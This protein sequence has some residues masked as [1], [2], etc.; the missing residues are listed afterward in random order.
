MESSLQEK[1]GLK[2]EYHAHIR[3]KEYDAHIRSKENVFKEK[4]RISKSLQ[5][6]TQLP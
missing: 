3:S 4:E 5:K 1:E 2:E 6:M